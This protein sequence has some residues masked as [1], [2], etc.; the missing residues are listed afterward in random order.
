MGRQPCCDKVG[1]KRGPWNAEEDKKLM[2]FILNNG[3]NCWRLVP[4][5]AGLLRCGKSCRLRWTNYLRPDLKRGA[6]S[7]FEEN[8]IIEL[9]SRLGNRWSRIA[10]QLPGRTDNE[11]KNHWNT[12]IK[13]KLKLL[14]LDPDTHKP[15]ETGCTKIE[16][17]THKE[18]EKIQSKSEASL[19]K[20][21]DT[22]SFSPSYGGLWESWGVEELM[23]PVLIE[24]EGLVVNQEESHGQSLEQGSSASNSC[25]S[26]ATLEEDM[27]RFWGEECFLGERMGSF[28]E[29]EEQQHCLDRFFFS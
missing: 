23:D 4:K 15:N 17:E 9:H 18:E 13:K 29:F 16:E 2:N 12:R 3:Q 7:E 6:L 8:K 26:S 22:A 28:Y 10:S 27:K 19:S 21:D 20:V 25:I 11:I 1:L 14:G 24:P 5:L